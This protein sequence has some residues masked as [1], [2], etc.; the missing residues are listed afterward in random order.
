VEELIQAAA[1]DIARHMPD[2]S[3]LPLG[4]VLAEA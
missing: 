4:L 2:P 3:G 1:Q